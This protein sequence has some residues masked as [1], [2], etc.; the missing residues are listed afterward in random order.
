[1]MRSR[2]GIGL[3]M[4][5]TGNR[6]DKAADGA[7]CAAGK[8]TTPRGIRVAQG[9]RDN[10]S[11]DRVRVMADVLSA[12]ATR[13]GAPDRNKPIHA[14]TCEARSFATSHSD[15][16]AGVTAP[17]VARS[18]SSWLA[19]KGVLLPRAQCRTDQALRL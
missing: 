1:M 18:S 11:E 17:S 10:A 3:T 13:G 16:I 2:N 6:M 8:D 9:E 7:R 19:S 15:H 5:I 14:G 4:M 12:S